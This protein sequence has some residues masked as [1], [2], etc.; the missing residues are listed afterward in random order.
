MSIL[1]PQTQALPPFLDS[2]GVATVSITPLSLLLSAFCLPPGEDLVEMLSLCPPWPSD[3]QPLPFCPFCVLLHSGEVLKLVDTMPVP[4]RSSMTARFPAMANALW[5]FYVSRLFP[6]GFSYHRD[7]LLLPPFKDAKCS[8]PLR[9]VAHFQKSAWV[10]QNTRVSG[11]VRFV[12]FIFFSFFLCS[13][14]NEGDW[15]NCL[16]L[17]PTHC[18]HI[19]EGSLF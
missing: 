2:P 12:S 6:P 3:W 16:T 19:L 1:P 5:S 13:S 8:L 9:R 7:S 18:V 17:G 10:P 15:P 11:S 4:P 14:W